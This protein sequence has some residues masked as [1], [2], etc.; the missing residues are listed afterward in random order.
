MDRI[1]TTLR[2]I[3]R[4]VLIDLDNHIIY[5]S[6]WVTNTIV[7]R[8]R[9][10]LASF[11]KNERSSGLHHLAVGQGLDTWDQTGAPIPDP[12]TTTGLQTP[13]DP[14]IPVEKLR[15]VYLNS[16]DKEVEEQT[17]RLQI[18][19]TLDANYPPPIAPLNSYPLREFGL[20]ARLGDTDYMLN[21]IRHPLISKDA[22]TS[23]I[24]VI[25]LYF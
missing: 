1:G 16:A 12:V 23:L 22:S 6:G 14:P 11:I 15:I 5:D 21:C 4:D 17:N 20:F 13:Y 10:L 24:R 8:C 18:T 19:A 7:D 3:Y 25:R 9:I 2:G